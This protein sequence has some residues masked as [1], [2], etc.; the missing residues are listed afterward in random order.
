ML[1]SRLFYRLVAEDTLKCI[2]IIS[3][4]LIYGKYCTESLHLLNQII[5]IIHDS[6][7]N[8]TVF[9]TLAAAEKQGLFIFILALCFI[10]VTTAITTSLPSR[11][12][13]VGLGWEIFFAREYAPSRPDFPPILPPETEDPATH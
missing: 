4:N 3:I 10:Y 7:V 5:T 13:S 6:V 11:Q 8:W 12:W 1:Q 9:I 2:S